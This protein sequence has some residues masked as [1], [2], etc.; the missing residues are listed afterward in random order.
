MKHVVMSD[1]P[2]LETQ[3]RARAIRHWLPCAALLP[4]IASMALSASLPMPPD[5]VCIN[6]RCQ[7]VT[8]AVRVRSAAEFVDSIGID[9]HFTQFSTPYVTRLPLVRQKLLDLGIRHVREGAID[10]QGGFSDEDQ[11]EL[12]RDLGRSGIRV[13]FIFNANMSR[14]FVQGFPARVAPAFE[15]YEFPNEFNNTSNGHWAAD[16]RAWAVTLRTYVRSNPA[17]ASYPIIGPSLIGGDDPPTA[18]GDLSA[19][20]DFGNIHAYYSSR[21]PG[22][23]GWGGQSTSPCSTWHYGSTGFDLCNARRVSGQKP[24]ISTET[25][26]GSDATAADQVNET[27]QA[28]YLARALLMHL[29][30]GITRTF[31]YQLIDSGDDG[32][33]AFGLLTPTG[34]EK[35]AYREIRSLIAQMQDSAAPS[36]LTALP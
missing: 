5:Q 15:A 36:R 24:I 21:P 19:Y 14:E 33:G 12:F 30:A 31:I 25:G 8:A 23:D 11:A 4:F 17:T 10:S 27:M 34:A 9:A 20:M 13:T 3:S 16:L 22:T 26:W 7:P 6:N 29:E 35:P 18:L 2:L 32:F 1:S 28:K